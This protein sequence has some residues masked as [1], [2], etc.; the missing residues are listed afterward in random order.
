MPDFTIR[1]ARRSDLE[2][3]SAL[4]A[5]S[6]ASDRLSPRSFRRLAVAP[7]AACRVAL[8]GDGIAGYSLLLFRANAHVARLYSIAVH[9]DRRGR[10][11]AQLLLDDAAGTAR[12]RRCRA[13]RL[14]VRE[15]NAAAIRLYERSGFRAIGRIPRYYAD[16]ATALR[17]EKQLMAR[18]AVD[19]EAEEDRSPGGAAGILPYMTTG[20]G[21]RDRRR[22][23]RRRTLLPIHLPRQPACRRT[24]SFDAPPPRRPYQDK[25]R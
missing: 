9:P 1:T 12:K 19:A 7:T 13:L 20:R 6:F 5:L 25:G 15:D 16:K 18:P 2:A 4:E 10:G 22:L 3:L 8:A 21:G 17:Y 14:E 24:A 23:H 11:L